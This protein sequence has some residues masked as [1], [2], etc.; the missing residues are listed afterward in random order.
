MS[1]FLEMKLAMLNALDQKTYDLLGYEKLATVTCCHTAICHESSVS[2]LTV[3]C[4]LCFEIPEA[5]R[6]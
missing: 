4:Q 3:R 6:F 5:T 1:D 2:A